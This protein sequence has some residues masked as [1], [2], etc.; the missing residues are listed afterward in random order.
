MVTHN[1]AVKTGLDK[2][3]ATRLYMT[4]M[5]LIALF[6]GAVAIA[7]APIFVRLSQ[8]GPSAT[9]FWRLSLVLPALA[10]WTALEQRA[11]QAPRRPSS[12]M[13]Y[14]Q[15]DAAGLF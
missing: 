5:A 3:A 12:G 10:L 6:G 2:E 15:L 4:R 8:G 7:F 11:P 1:V 9:A 13:E 14:W